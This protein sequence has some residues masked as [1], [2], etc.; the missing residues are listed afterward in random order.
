MIASSQKA[1]SLM[2]LLSSRRDGSGRQ[3]AGSFKSS[4]ES[5]E[6][7][8]W[9]QRSGD[10]PSRRLRPRPLLVAYRAIRP[11]AL[12]R[13]VLLP[14]WTSERRAVEK[15]TIALSTWVRFRGSTTQ[16]FYGGDDGR[17][18]KTCLACCIIRLLL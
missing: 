5:R 3:D 10:F 13:A 14:G 17:A 9:Q 7:L 1:A 2:G 15:L 18:P 16:V 11:G 8:F 6:G 4:A 12:E